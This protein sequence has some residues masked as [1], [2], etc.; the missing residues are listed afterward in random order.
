MEEEEIIT[1]QTPEPEAPKKEPTKLD[2]FIQRLS[3]YPDKDT[4]KTH[5]KEIAKDLQCA[6]SLGYKA[7]KKVEQFKPQ[8]AEAVEPT[9]KIHETKPEPIEEAE[10]EEEAIT[11]QPPIGEEAPAELVAEDTM[12]KLKGVLERSL[13]RL[14]NNGIEIASGMEETLSS[15]ESKDTAILLPF[16]IWRISKQKLTEDNFIDM[17]CISHFG[18]IIIKVVNKKLK[19]RKKEKPKEEKPPEPTKQEPPPPPIS[20]AP[21]PTP[22]PEIP[23]EPTKQEPAVPPEK[24]KTAGFMKNLT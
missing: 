15:Q 12:S 11:E 18:S 16:I 9:L 7:I 5:I 17:T 8:Q 4:A 24:P 19:E 20:Q 23:K 3:E 6:P 1:E 10:L 13:E 14:F 22:T 2:L 21:P